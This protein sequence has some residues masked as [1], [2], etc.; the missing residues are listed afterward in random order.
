MGPLPPS[1]PSRPLLMDSSDLTSSSLNV[2][3]QGGDAYGSNMDC[4][5]GFGVYISGKLK[6]LNTSHM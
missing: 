3:L 6:P 1:S 2:W 5:D 4:K